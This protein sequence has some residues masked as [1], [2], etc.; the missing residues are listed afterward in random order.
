MNEIY[1]SNILETATFDSD[2]SIQIEDHLR[3]MGGIDAECPLDLASAI[4]FA[5]PTET[6]DQWY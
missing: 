1:I 3:R 2:L 6:L 4:D 5:L